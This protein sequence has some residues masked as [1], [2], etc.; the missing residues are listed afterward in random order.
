M[1]V[2]SF[3]PRSGSDLC[4]ARGEDDAIL[5]VRRFLRGRGLHHRMPAVCRAW[6]SLL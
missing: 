2:T 3:E 6:E 5:S 4:Q 1:D